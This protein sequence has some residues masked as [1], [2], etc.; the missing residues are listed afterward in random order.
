MLRALLQVMT[1]VSVV[2]PFD[3]AWAGIADVDDLPIWSAAV[4]AGAEFIVSHNLRDFPPRD[5]HGICAF[6]GIEFITV[7]NLVREV[8][9][10]DPEAIAPIPIPMS[11][12]IA[13]QRR[14]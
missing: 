1:F 12:H 8:L 4:R 11:G 6:G 5:A 3:A 2:P 13:H 14:A 7:E 10:L 9:G